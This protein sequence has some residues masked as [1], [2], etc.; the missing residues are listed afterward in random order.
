MPSVLPSSTLRTSE[1]WSVDD[2]AHL[3]ARHGKILILH[4]LLPDFAADILVDNSGEA[5]KRL[6]I[7]DAGQYLIRPD[8]YIAYRCAQRDLQGVKQSLSN[9]LFSRV[10]DCRQDFR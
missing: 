3:T 1:G 7:R 10:D 5:L 4:Y 9:W 6:G 2:I 8:G